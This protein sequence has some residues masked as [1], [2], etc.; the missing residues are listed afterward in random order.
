MHLQTIII[1]SLCESRECKLES[2]LCLD[3]VLLQT[4]WT[5][6]GCPSL[7]QNWSSISFFR[8]RGYEY[9]CKFL[10]IDGVT[11]RWKI[12]KIKRTFVLRR[13]QFPFMIFFPSWLWPRLSDSFL[14]FPVGVLFPP[15]CARARRIFR[16][17]V[18]RRDRSREIITEIYSGPVWPGTKEMFLSHSKNQSSL[19][20]KLVFKLNS[21]GFNWYRLYVH[22]CL[23]VINLQAYRWNK[24]W[25]N[26]FEFVEIIRCMY[27]VIKYHKLSKKR[28]KTT[29]H[30]RE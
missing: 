27:D 9:F 20:A 21:R 22:T 23:I 7:V 18:L 25:K 10:L 1:S 19:F 5:R 29:Q 8:I 11:S 28:L 17:F 3:A 16:S 24:A 6:P 30:A 2:E 14:V 26:H 12:W 4:G 15:S 13:H